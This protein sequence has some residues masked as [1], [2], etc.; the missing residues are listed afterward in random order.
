MRGRTRPRSWTRPW[1]P[2]LL[3]E[4][5][6]ALI[7]IAAYGRVRRAD[8]RRDAVP[9]QC[10]PEIVV[11]GTVAGNKRVGLAPV[12]ARFHEQIGLTL[13]GVASDR[14]AV[15]ADEGGAAVQRN[16]LAETGV[17]RTVASGELLH[18]TPRAIRLGKHVGRA[19]KGVAADS[20]TVRADEGRAAVERNRGAKVVVR[21]AIACGELLTFTP[22]AVRLGEQVGRAL[23]SVAAH[24]GSECT[25]KKGIVGEYD[26]IAEFVPRQAVARGQ[27][28]SLAPAAVRF[29]EQVGRTLETVVAIGANECSGTAER[30]RR[31]EVAVCRAVA[32]GDLLLQPD[33]R[34]PWREF[35]IAIY[36]GGHVGKDAKAN[37]KGKE[38]KQT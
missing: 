2:R 8:E 36:L 19:L 35:R 1:C 30:S 25:D 32:S 7:A 10:R 29:G 9:R 28:L 11:R 3:V 34:V 12:A 26:P 37:Q 15:R 6:R 13:I 33:Q 24:S 4:V 31:A 23:A 20:G 18:L 14:G 5:S 16:R 22:S 21:R 17:R 27:L 38:D